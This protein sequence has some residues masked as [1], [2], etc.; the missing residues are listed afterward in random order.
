MRNRFEGGI[1]VDQN[2]PVAKAEGEIGYIM[3]QCNI[4]GA[5]DSEIGE[6]ME[7]T[8]QVKAKEKDPE[9][10]VARAREILGSKQDY[11]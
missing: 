11:H 1:P 4:M 5:N 9:E 8:K 2:D 3:Q 10:A 6:L 7:L